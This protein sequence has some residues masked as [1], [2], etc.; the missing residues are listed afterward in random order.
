MKLRGLPG[1]LALGLLASVIGHA[2]GYGNEHAMGGPYH[3]TFLTLAY[4]GVGVFLLAALA[5]AVASAG[6]AAE[7]TI[8]AT[9]LR[10]WIPDTGVLAL[11]TS[12][13][14]GVAEV[15]EGSH[16]TGTSLAI[17]AALLIA[18]VAVR[19]FALAVI[20][21]ISS[22]A[23]AIDTAAFAPRSYGRYLSLERPLAVP[24]I[25]HVRR[26]FARP[27]PDLMQRV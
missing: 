9:R 20:A 18:I 16:A 24:S 3:G 21:V 23:I 7:G 10:R 15:I 4:A 2:A 17:V 6:A 12:L 26:L 13:W 5:V 14:F 19:A 27:P 11:A 22:I 8:V 25:A 1:A